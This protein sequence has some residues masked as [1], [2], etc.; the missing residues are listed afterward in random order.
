[1]H[2]GAAAMKTAQIL[3]ALNKL[4]VTFMEGMIALDKLEDRIESYIR[5]EKEKSANATPVRNVRRKAGAKGK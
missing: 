5:R 3:K 1:M 2:C 4:D